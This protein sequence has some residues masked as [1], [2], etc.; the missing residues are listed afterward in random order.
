MECHC[1]VR[2]LDR[3]QTLFTQ[4]LIEQLSV[5]NHFKFKAL[6]AVIAAD[7]CKA[8]WASDNNLLLTLWSIAK[9]NIKCFNIFT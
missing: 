9:C 1:G 2:H 4:Q 6:L 3:Q 8:M 7:R 5:V